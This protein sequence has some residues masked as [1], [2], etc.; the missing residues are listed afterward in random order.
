MEIIRHWI[1]IQ[2]LSYN[3]Q[4]L[5]RLPTRQDGVKN[6]DKAYQDSISLAYPYLSLSN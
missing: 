1:L 2:T 5:T 3:I 4:F 6:R